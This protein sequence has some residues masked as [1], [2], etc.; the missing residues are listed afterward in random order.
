MLGWAAV[1]WSVAS[2]LGV[3]RRLAGL[4]EAVLLALRLPRVAGE[5]A[6][7]LQLGAEFLVQ[8]D[9]G[10]RD[11]VPQG[12]GLAGDA[13]T[14]ERGDRVVALEGVGDPQRLG[15]EPAVGRVGEVVL[16][17]PAVQ[18]EG[19]GARQEPDPGDG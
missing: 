11:A 18:P 5:E 17:R 19:A 7:L 3:L 2:A 9:Q 16:Q 13:A 8:V 4:L 15:D 12:A 10:T 14:G 6:A 1:R